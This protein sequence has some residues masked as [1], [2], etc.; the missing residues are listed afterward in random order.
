SC[1]IAS[2]SWDSS[3]RRRDSCVAPSGISPQ[4]SSHLSRCAIAAGSTRAPHKRV[5]RVIGA[6]SSTP[7]SSYGGRS[8]SSSGLGASS[9]LPPDGGS[10]LHPPADVA[11]LGSSPRVTTDEL[12]ALSELQEAQS[13][14]CGIRQSREQQ[15]V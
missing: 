9:T 4:T 13:A 2:T 1:A 11:V 10:M 12:P 15:V 3:R 14:N 5:W 6:E 7:G 8:T